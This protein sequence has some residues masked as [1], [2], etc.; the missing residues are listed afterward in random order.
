MTKTEKLLARVDAAIQESR[1]AR[2]R[3]HRRVIEGRD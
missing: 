1:E 3:F 2:E